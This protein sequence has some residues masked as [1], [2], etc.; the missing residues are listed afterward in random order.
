MFTRALIGLAALALA[1]AAYAQPEVR[2][3]GRWVAGCP[4]CGVE[5]SAFLGEF[6]RGVDISGT[7]LVVTYQDAG[8]VER[9]LTFTPPAASTMTAGPTL[10]SAD[11]DVGTGELTLTLSTGATVDA[12]LSA[13]QTA[14]QVT[15]AINAALPGLVTQSEAEGGTGTEARLWSSQRVGQAIAALAPGGQT[16]GLTQPQV[17]ARVQSGLAGA[18]TGNTETGI[19][20]TY[21]ADDNTIDFVVVDEI[22]RPGASGLPDAADHQGSIAVSGNQVLESIDH[23]EVDKEV[24]FK[25]YGT[26]T[27]LSGEPAKTSQEN[28]YQGAFNAPPNINAYDASDFLWDRGSQVWIFKQNQNDATWRSFGGPAN[29]AHGSLYADEDTA[30]RHVTT[31]GQLGDVFIIGTGT[32]QHAFIVTSFTAAVAENWQWD[33]L[34]LTVGDVSTAITD[35]LSDA[36]PRPV[37]VAG[38]AGTGDSAARDTHAHAGVASLTCTDGVQCTQTIGAVGI[39]ARLSSVAP[40]AVGETESAGGSDETISRS[41]HRHA[42]VTSIAVA[43]TGVAV[44]RAQGAVTITGS[45]QFSWA[46]Q[47][48]TLIVPELNEN[49]ITTA[50]IS[51][52]DTGTPDHLAFL[53]WTEANLNRVSHLPVGA[54]IGLR[55]G[56]TNLRILRVEA[57]FDSSGN[58]YEVRNV[59]SG[60]LNESA[61]GTATELLLTAGAASDSGLQIAAYSASATYSRGASNSFVTDGG[62]LYIYTSGTGRSSGHNPGE[63]PEYW[64]RVSHGAE[65]I[66]AGS[67]SHRYKAGTFLL[68]N[69]AIYLATTN[70]TTPRAAAYVIANAG[71]DQE[72][73]LVNGAGAGG[74]FTLRQGS[75]APAGSLGADGDWYLRTTNGQFYERVAGTWTSR[76]TDQLGQAGSGISQAQGDARYARQSNDLSDLD[77]A[78][79][80]RTNLGLGDAAERHVG[81][82]QGNLPQLDASGDLPTA[83]IADAI[84]R[85]NSPTLTG[86]PRAPTAAAGTSTTQLATTAFVQSYT[87]PDESVTRD[88][89][90]ANAAGEGKVP[91]DD[92]MQFDG[93]GDLGVNTQRV[94]QTVSEWVQHFASGDGH[95]TSGHSGK[96]HEYTSPN[97]H[98]RIGSVQYDFDPLNDGAGGGTGKT[99]QVFIL[100]LTGRNI[101]V[102]LGS[103]EV[104]S[105][106]SLQHRFH[107]TDGVMINP[108]VRIGIGLHR[109]DGG[110]NEGLSVRFGTESQDSPRESYDDASNDFNFVGRFNHDRPTP[111]VNDSVGGTTANQIYGNPEIFYQIIHTHESL[112]GDGTVSVSHISSGSSADG[113]VLTADGSAG[114]AFEALPVA[115]TTARGIVELAT[116]TEVLNADTTRAATGAG[117]YSV[118]GLQVSTAER[119]A[120]SATSVRR[121]SPADVHSM[122]D[123]H[124]PSGGG[125]GA[126]GAVTLT[127][128]TEAEHNF[129]FPSGTLQ[130]GQNRDLFDTDITL[131]TDLAEGEL[132]IIRLE[133]DNGE[134]NVH[135]TKAHLEELAV[136]APV[137]WSTSAT[138]TTGVLS[139]ATKNVFYHPLGQN[140]GLFIGRSDEDPYRLLWGWSNAQSITFTLQL[141]TVSAGGAGGQ[142]SPTPGVAQLT[143]GKVQTTLYRWNE[144]FVGVPS[145]PTAHWRFDDEWDGTTPFQGGGW[146]T[147]RINAGIAADANP[148][149]SE[150]TWTLWI[151]TEETRRRVVND[152]YTYD[153]SGYSL[154]ADNDAAYSVTGTSGW[155]TT[156]ATG[157]RFLRLRTSTGEYTQPIPIGSLAGTGIS[158][159]PFLSEAAIY[160]RGPISTDHNTYT[161]ATAVDISDYDAILVQFQSFDTNNDD[162][163][164]DF[165]NLGE[166]I[167]SKPPD[168]WPVTSTENSWITDGTYQYLYDAREA[169]PL[170]VSMI[171][172]GQFTNFVDSD[173][174]IT[175]QTYTG[176]GIP[177][178]VRDPTKGHYLVTAGRFKLIGSGEDDVTKFRV[179]DNPANNN[180]FNRCRWWLSGLIGN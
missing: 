87:I 92:T 139:G 23:G 152:A 146:Y 122:I 67:G 89:L 52:R 24:V 43:G 90:A 161:F 59:T 15:A 88:K 154:F 131:P 110:N 175:S 76:Y 136:A 150:A 106:N 174:A 99:Y 73:L 103:S 12:D 10:T 51:L 66:N 134:A 57:E 48:D 41:R 1:P 130:S 164:H 49:A 137:T 116:P 65:F 138:G 56:T 44:N 166:V 5:S 42:G 125:G 107:F 84:A 95:D 108:N 4:T 64:F 31:A 39:V 145:S 157:D 60:I 71:D 17:D 32:G 142:E 54:H 19:T 143:P 167:L 40:V 53:G 82:G 105:G 91:I 153:D 83:V 178:S 25:R 20:V 21:Q 18:V 3:Q 123:T 46:V 169:T 96:Y 111:S 140:R 72:F 93:S 7:S 16:S 114:V 168:G 162:G 35:S 61:S 109:T 177:N 117:V 165:T 14:A 180:G 118:T 179:F 34:G 144:D 160:Q 74:G 159:L 156:F 11:F 119:T 33:P 94:V 163:A 171:D 129:S 172:D 8:G 85:L 148:D 27:V 58:R 68:I 9:T 38:T 55:Q 50:R 121:F 151:A 81:L 132:F 79:T 102:I 149:F 86:T 97:T 158:W 30:G 29:F 128:R 135:M 69:N 80:A 70:I 75:T 147:S 101:D 126:S 170:Q 37:A 78:S 45:Q 22:V 63:H 173:D 113:T 112:V 115:S 176:P 62:E 2:L 98:R 13:L 26:R 124:A 155:H 133:S 104:Y 6:V 127:P 77:S 36:T 28:R 141:V 47:I 120:G 100:E